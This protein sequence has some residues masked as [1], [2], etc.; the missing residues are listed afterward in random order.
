[1]HRGV[2]CLLYSGEVAELI[3]WR[4]ESRAFKVATCCAARLDSTTGLLYQ[5]RTEELC[6]PKTA[7]WG[8][9]K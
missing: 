6:I 7:G 2:G 5:E 4:R 3:D 1:M 8:V 9:R